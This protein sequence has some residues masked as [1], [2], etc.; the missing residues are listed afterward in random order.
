MAKKSKKT[1]PKKSKK[2]DKK[3]KAAKKGKAAK[4][5]KDEEEW[6]DEEEWEDVEDD[7]EDDDDEEWDEDE[8]EDDEEWDDEDDDE[9]DDDEEEEETFPLEVVIIGKG[10]SGMLVVRSETLDGE[11]QEYDKDDLKEAEM[12]FSR[13][14]AIGGYFIDSALKSDQKKLAKAL[15]KADY[16]VTF[17]EAPEEEEEEKPAKKKAKK[18]APKKAA[19]KKAKKKD[20]EDEK[21][22]KVKVANRKCYNSLVNAMGLLLRGLAAEYDEDD[23]A[24]A[25]AYMVQNPD[26][27][28]PFED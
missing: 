25:Y 6:D 1:A 7:D 19:A 9:E 15:A 20:D 5:V 16:E 13:K 23:A 22:V 24:N 21:P 10:R 14:K 3:A 17:V 27:A 28:N 11:E 18:A 8:D 4:K 26:K 12:T 2:T